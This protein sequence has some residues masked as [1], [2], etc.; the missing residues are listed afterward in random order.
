V[1]VN[2]RARARWLTGG[3]NAIYENGT[4][5]I[6][7]VGKRKE[8]TRFLI[9][10]FMHV[11][12]VRLSNACIFISKLNKSIC[13]SRRSSFRCFSNAR[14]RLVVPL[15]F[16]ALM[17]ASRI[18]S[19]TARD[20]FNTDLMHLREICLSLRCVTVAS[21]ISA[22]QSDRT[23]NVCYIPGTCASL[24]IVISVYITIG[25]NTGQISCL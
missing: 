8:E 23:C 15:S 12:V 18:D 5:N 2:V 19:R 9:Y 3:G 24:I 1:H 21:F 10:E 20:V 22:Q 17:K 14:I 25:K 4:R 6:P 11:Y 16:R 13:K 7:R